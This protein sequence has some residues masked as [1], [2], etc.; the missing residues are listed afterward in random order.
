LDVRIDVS[1]I[2]FSYCHG[3]KVKLFVFGTLLITSVL[4]GIFIYRKDV[5]NEYK[6]ESITNA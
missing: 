4:S 1:V 6:R 5:S 3:N 2:M